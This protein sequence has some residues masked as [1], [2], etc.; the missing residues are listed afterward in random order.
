MMAGIAFCRSSS[1]QCCILEVR[2]HKVSISESQLSI[3]PAEM[4][5]RLGLNVMASVP[6]PVCQVLPCL[7]NSVLFDE[8]TV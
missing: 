1:F 4:S 8:N 2:E 3:S 7:M 5:D 6:G